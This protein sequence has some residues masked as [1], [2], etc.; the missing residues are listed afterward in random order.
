MQTLPLLIEGRARGRARAAI[1]RRHGLGR[2]PPGRTARRRARAPRP[3]RAPRRL[4]VINA[5]TA[6]QI[7]D[8]ASDESGRPF[9]EANVALRNVVDPRPRAPAFAAKRQF[10]LVTAENRAVHGLHAVRS[11]RQPAQVAAAQVGQDCAMCGVLA[12][13]A[14]DYRCLV[15]RHERMVDACGSIRSLEILVGKLGRS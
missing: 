1:G 8:L 6:K 13:S 11:Q 2:P 3:W 9:F 14:C 15:E 5:D 7:H 12:C 10:A 4:V